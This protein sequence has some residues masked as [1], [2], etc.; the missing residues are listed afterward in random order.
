VCTVEHAA[1][2]SI[3]AGQWVKEAL[4]KLFWK[5]GGGDVIVASRGMATFQRF[6]LGLPMPNC[7]VFALELQPGGQWREVDQANRA[8]V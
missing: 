7:A 3:D 5:I 4:C 2:V 1:G 6:Q 8:E